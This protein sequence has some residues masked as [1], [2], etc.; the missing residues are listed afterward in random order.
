MVSVDVSVAS[1][2]VLRDGHVG[3]GADLVGD[4]HL[5]RA[6]NLAGHLP[7]RLVGNILALPLHTLLADWAG[8]AATTVPGLRLSLP[9]AVA[10][11][12][13]V[14]RGV[15]LGAVLG[16]DISALLGVGGVHHHVVLRVALLLVVGVVLGLAVL[17]LVAVPAV[18]TTGG[19]VHHH[20]Q[21]QDD[22]EPQ[23]DVKIFPAG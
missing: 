16:H 2:V 4:L 17:D 13:Y 3:G 12:D 21:A 23:H 10:V 1:V 5:H 20:G 8:V 11:G 19:T 15:G 18:A 14:G 9:V 6:A 22:H 7:L